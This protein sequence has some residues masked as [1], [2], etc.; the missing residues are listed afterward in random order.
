MQQF[1]KNCDS[2]IRKSKKVLRLLILSINVKKFQKK[3]KKI[4]KK[5]LLC[6]N[7]TKPTNIEEE[8]IQ[9]SNFT[10]LTQEQ[11]LED[12]K[13]D[14]LK[15]RGTKAAITDFAILLGGFVSDSWHID[16][17]SSLEG[18][19]GF[20]W[21]KSGYKNSYARVVDSSGD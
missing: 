15:K 4:A 2:L 5:K 1:Q 13:L 3:V 20:Y 16:N 19:T 17:D 9:M 6:Y 8:V 21:T 12:N 10:F 14:I 7:K 11:C 18:R